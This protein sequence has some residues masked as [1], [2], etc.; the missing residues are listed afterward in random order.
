MG[1]RQGKGTYSTV[2]GDI[3]EGDLMKT[4]CMERALINGQMETSIRNL[5]KW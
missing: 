3:Y 2:Q 4:E 5:F 1:S